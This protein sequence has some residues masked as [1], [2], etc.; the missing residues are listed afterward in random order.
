MGFDNK[1]TNLSNTDQTLQSMRT[2]IMNEKDLIF[3]GTN[4]VVIDSQGNITING[5]TTIGDMLEVLGDTN[6]ESTLN[7]E[8]NSNY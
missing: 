3:K 1:D 8:D 4:D 7:V 6:L 5:I 2:V